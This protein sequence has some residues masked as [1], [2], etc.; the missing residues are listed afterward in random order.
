MSHRPSRTQTRQHE[1]H[2]RATAQ[3]RKPHSW[4]S[5]SAEPA[6]TKPW[7]PWQST[8]LPLHGLQATGQAQR[9]PAFH[10]QGV[11][12]DVE[13][14]P[15]SGSPTAKAAAIA[16]ASGRNTGSPGQGRAPWSDQVAPPA[17]TGQAHEVRDQSIQRLNRPKARSQGHEAADL[18]GPV[19]PSVSAGNVRAAR[20]SPP[21]VRRCLMKLDRPNNRTQP[22]RLERAG[23]R[24]CGGS[25]CSWVG[26]DMGDC[27]QRAQT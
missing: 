10:H 23:R 20:I 19:W 9:L 18:V 15:Q 12:H 17:R 24:V 1:G 5:F 16:P 27:S 4:R 6:A 13:T 7:Q 2:R 21:S 11:Y 26:C 14:A 25:I 22:E 3:I 8:W